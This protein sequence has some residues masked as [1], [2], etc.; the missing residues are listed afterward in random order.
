MALLVPVELETPQ[1]LLDFREIH[2]SIA[3]GWRD[4]YIHRANTFPTTDV[5]L[6]TDVLLAFVKTELITK[7]IADHGREY[8]VFRFGCNSIGA[9][10]NQMEMYVCAM[11]AGEN[12]PPNNI[13]YKCSRN[14]NFA[15]GANAQPDPN[16]ST[17]VNNYAIRITKQGLTDEP[18]GIA[19]EV[20]KIAPTGVLNESHWAIF[21]G[22][23]DVE[24]PARNTVIVQGI[25]AP[26]LVTTPFSAATKMYDHGNQCCPIN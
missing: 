20:A 11:G 26:V 3:Q 22:L 17:V 8:I 16:F 19:F 10:F 5:N 1:S 4:E 7:L 15:P 6:R 12:G 2:A 23:R 9:R 25:S 18:K 13:A 24:L 21:M 14:F